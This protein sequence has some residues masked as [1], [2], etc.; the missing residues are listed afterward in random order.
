MVTYAELIEEAQSHDFINDYETADAAVKAT[1]GIMVSR[2]E[3]DDD[4]RDFIK[5]L[6]E[7]LDFAELRS[8]QVRPT[9]VS[10]DQ[11]INVIA[12]QF[13]FTMEQSEQLVKGLLHRVK[14]NIRE[15]NIEYW[16][17]KLPAEWQKLVEQA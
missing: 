15:E 12:R 3:T 13:K 7:P 10:P 1:F 9:E 17:S 6:P 14:E 4:A 5:F 11:Y 16:E 2:M 8:H